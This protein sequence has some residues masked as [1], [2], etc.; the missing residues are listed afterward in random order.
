VA[1]QALYRIGL[2]AFERTFDLD[3]ALDAFREVTRIPRAG[4]MAWEALLRV[5]EVQTAK[6]DLAGAA[7]ALAS[8]AGS[9]PQE[10]RDRVTFQQ[11]RLLAYDGRIDSALALLN[12]LA[13]A[14]DRDLANDAI[15]LQVFLQEHRGTMPAL[16]GFLRAE[17]LQRQRKYA[18]AM[19]QFDKV[20]GDSPTS[21]ISDDALVRAADL[22]VLLA[23]PREAV[24]AYRRFV[25]E[26][27]ASM[28]RD[29]AL[30]RAGDVTE[31]SLHDQAGALQ[32]YEIFLETF[33]HSLFVEEVRM[34]I[35]RLRGE[36]S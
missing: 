25:D 6:N 20:A 11:A 35:R 15:G 14:V 10:V 12:P 24:A 30:F 19:A 1:V 3:G 34:R 31:R 7:G 2:V 28:L 16:A 26:R 4:A 29:R 9:A 23:R 36:P 21:L 27:A 13:G 33:P 5:A 22:L 18:E 32:I 8:I 17:L